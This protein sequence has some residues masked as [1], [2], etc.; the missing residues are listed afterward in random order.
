MENLGHYCASKFAVIGF[1]QS[2][3]LGLATH[4]ICVNAVCPCRIKGEMTNRDITV[5]AKARGVSETEFEK[6]Y[7]QPIPAV[8]LGLPED[9]ADV[10]V[11]L[12]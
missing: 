8:R 1:A 5:L 9:G 10:V 11:F 6:E 3:A 7:I 2:L 4:K 12:C